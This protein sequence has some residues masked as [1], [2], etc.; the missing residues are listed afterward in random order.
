MIARRGVVHPRQN[1]AVSI[2]FAD[3]LQFPRCPMRGADDC[4]LAIMMKAPRPGRVKTRLTPAHSPEQV[5][6]LYKALVEDSIGLARRVPAR[7]V[8][9]CPADDQPDLVQWLP[10][11]VSVVPQ[12]GAGLAAGLYSTFDALCGEAA[13]RVIAFNADSPHLPAASLESAFT[14][15]IDADLVVGPCD[16]GGYY[17]VGAKRAHEGLFDAAAMGRESACE[18][19]L[20]EA[21]RL[22]LRVAL[23]A[24]HYDIDLPQDLVR[25]AAEL[26]HDSA[27]AP[28]TAAILASWANPSA[29]G[30]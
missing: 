6:A 21:S 14:S 8:A 9:V 2:E 30:G 25:L 23:N 16:D 24:E 3:T 4:V 18:A 7:I 20:N 29:N 22:G 1:P 11:D 19:L 17:L 5:V 13:R 15:L 12:R 27:R 26:V 10:S 28:R